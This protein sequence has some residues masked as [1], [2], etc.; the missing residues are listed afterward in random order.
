MPQSITAKLP[1]FLHPI[2]AIL[3]TIW[4]LLDV[5]IAVLSPMAIIGFVVLAIV[6]LDG[7]GA[8][9][10][11][12]RTLEQH[13]AVTTGKWSPPSSVPGMAYVH[14]DQEQNGE[15]GVIVYIKYYNKETLAGLREGQQ[16]RVRYTYGPRVETRGFLVDEYAQVTGYVGYLTELFWPFLVCWLMVV[17]RPDFL[18]LGF[19]NPWKDG[20]APK[21][22]AQP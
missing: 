16:V 14:F 18:Y 3:R 13:S 5:L 10:Q 8:H 22:E 17:I 6:A 4:S 7:F 1:A 11:T 2:F 20:L 15:T 12:L 19:S 9:V 21:K